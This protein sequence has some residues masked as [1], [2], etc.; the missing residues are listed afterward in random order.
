MKSSL[1]IANWKMKLGLA[2]SLA[3][4][5]KLAKSAARNKNVEVVICPAFT[6]LAAVGEIIKGSGL[7]LGAQDCFW[8][9]AGA[10]TGAISPKNL[11][12]YGVE[13][14]LVG[15]SERREHLAE[16]NDMIHKKIRLLLSLG[17]T[18]VLCIGESFSERQE[19]LKEAVLIGEIHKALDGLLLNKLG[20][21]VIAY[22]P[23]WVIGS[24]QAVEAAEA[25][26]THQ[27]IKHALYDIF[28]RQAVDEQVKIIYGGS[29]DPGNIK[30]FL[31]E[32]TVRGVLVGTSSLDATIFS[33]I[34]A[35]AAKI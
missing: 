12:E 10:F 17:L 9:E 15:H 34:I 21:L 22:E 32:P 7:K 2:E 31:A 18:P 24:G 14:V 28:P 33:A 20:R 25:E 26:H 23:I 1:I 30:P 29:V 4:A 13:Y 11:Q 6:E 27:A 8:E 16:T 35:T 19:G 5:K 3:L